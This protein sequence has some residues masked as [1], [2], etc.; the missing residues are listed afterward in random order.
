[1][2]AVAVKEKSMFTDPFAEVDTQPV[3]VAGEDVAKVAVRVKDD[4]GEFK[5]AGILGKDYTIYKNSLVKDVVS[6]IMTRSQMKWTNLKTLWDGKRY[7]DYFHTVDPITS[8]KNGHEY[9]LHL[10]MMARNSYD[11]SSK[12]GLEFYIMNM[13]CT[14]QYIARKMMGYFAIR[15]TGENTIDVED[16]LQNVSLGATRLTQLAPRLQNFISKPLALPDLIEA[17]AADVIPSS[18]WGTAIEAL[19]KEVDS[20]TVFG[21]YQAL[22]FVTSHKIS[23]FNSISKGDEVTEYFFNKYKD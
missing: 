19:G 12:F 17:K 15:H 3:Q 14:N 8:I 21:L 2:E 6:D 7:V 13:I 23:G 16:A 22:T 11:G 9:P 20:S 10:G 1:M 5:L 18:Y 4:K